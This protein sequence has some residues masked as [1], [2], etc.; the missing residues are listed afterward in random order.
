[1][2]PPTLAAMRLLVLGGTVFLGRHLVDLALARGDEVTTFTRGRTG[3]V[4]EGARALHGDRD[5]GLD[6]LRSGSW[7]VVVDTSGYVPRVVG[8]SAELLRDRIQRYVFISTA[9]VYDI[10]QEDKRETAPTLQLTDSDTEDVGAHYGALKAA[11]ERTV[12]ELYGDRALLVR[13]GLIAGPL[14]PTERVTYW[15]GRGL[16][17]GEVLGPG[18][19][20]R[21]VTFV[22]VRDQAGWILEVAPTL[23]GTFNVGGPSTTFRELLQVAG[24]DGATWVPDDFLLAE[25]VKPWTDLPLWLPPTSGS[26]HAP[27]D[28]AVA[29]G[30]RW[31]PIADTMRDLRT[32]VE[33]RTSVPGPRESGGRRGEPAGIDADREATLLRRWHE[34]GAA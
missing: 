13:S 20:D 19:P 30:L 9:S 34:R 7:D 29:A 15:A 23:G 14:D 10:Q 12:T 27:S 5:G 3:E 2:P 25:Q 21:E 33:T 18:L 1:P 17:G 28:R 24:I 32:W 16:R 4:P 11:C 6:A 22:D 8:Q 31:R 26:L